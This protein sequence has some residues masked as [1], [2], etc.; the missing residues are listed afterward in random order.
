ME[1]GRNVFY[2]ELDHALTL[3]ESMELI[4]AEG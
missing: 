1:C 3:V 4:R 2:A